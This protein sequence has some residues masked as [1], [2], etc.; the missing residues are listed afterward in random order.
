VAHDAA[1]LGRPLKIGG[2]AR[3]AHPAAVA[4]GNRA[5]AYFDKLGRLVARPTVP[6]ELAISG[7]VALTTGV[8]TTLITAAAGTFHDL[9]TVFVCNSHATD[10][11]TLSFRDTTGGA[12]RFTLVVKAGETRFVTFPTPWPQ[13]AANTNWTVQCAGSI[14]TVFV[15]ALAVKDV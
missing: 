12:V 8:E 5:D 14:S 3:T 1:D 13:S 15:S 2:K 10:T 7:T 9:V 4:N 11:A 6:R